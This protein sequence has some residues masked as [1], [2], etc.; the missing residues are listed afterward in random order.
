MTN[1]LE[2]YKCNICGNLVQVIL[3]GKGELVCC[4]EPMLL[5]DTKTQESET[6]EKHV[7]VFE[8][9]DNQTE[10]KVGSVLHPM[11]EEHYIQF[12]QTVSEDGSCF[13]LKFFKPGDSPVMNISDFPSVKSAVA[14][15]NIHGL[16]IGDK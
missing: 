12:V 7:P 9:K 1:R 16:W 11:S 15:C 8:T 2:F 13:I 6:G 5:L 4:G 14:Y 3:P 10:L